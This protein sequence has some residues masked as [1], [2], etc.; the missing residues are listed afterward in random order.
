MEYFIYTAVF[1]MFLLVG[2]LFARV[3]LESGRENIFRSAHIEKIELIR[4]GGLWS[5]EVNIEY[6]FRYGKKLHQGEDYV[7]IDSLLTGKEFF[8]DDRNGFPALLTKDGEFIGEEHIETYLLQHTKELTCIFS[9]FALPH[10]R[11]YK[12]DKRKK[13]LFQNISIEFPWSKP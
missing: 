8:L 6:N 11:I 5:P 10:S 13:T 12:G 9:A 2:Y 7:R 4:I 3:F 1:L